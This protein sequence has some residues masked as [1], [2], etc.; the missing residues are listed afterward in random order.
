[1]QLGCVVRSA[2]EAEFVG[3]ADLD[4]LELKGDMLCGEADAF[5]ALSTRLRTVELP[6]TALTSPLPRRFGCRVVGLE[7]DQARAL[8][9]FRNVC[10]RGGS[11]GVHTV[12]LGSGQARSIP[13]GFP[14]AQ[15]V[16]QLQ[17]FLLVAQDECAR[18]G[19]TLALE[20]LNSTETN[21]INSCAEARVVIAGLVESGVRLTVDC[22]HIVSEG[23]S[24]SKE[25]AVAGE[26]IGHAHT[27]SIP[28]GTGDFREE[29]QAE[30]VSS[31]W[32]VGY[33]GGLTIEDEFTDFGQQALEAVGLFRHVLSTAAG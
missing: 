13:R 31:L 2:A 6:F 20:P 18:R 7:A 9:V 10:D 32:A 14:A 33:S 3:A 17:D 16:R 25:V 11:L 30:F 27:S 29:I 23:L 24:V 19:M 8:D 26:V 28:R 1:M 15:A 21:F 22:L 4:Y 5:R 12:V